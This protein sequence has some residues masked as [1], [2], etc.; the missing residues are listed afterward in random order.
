MKKILFLGYNR[1][2][3]RLIKFLNNLENYKVECFQKKLNL[4]KASK[5]DVII[6]FGY[7]YI[8]PIYL[9]KKLKKKI[10]NLHIGYLPYNRGAHPNFWSFID[11]TPKGVTIH[12]IDKNIDTGKIIYQKIV[13]FEFYKNY[14]SLT[15]K[16]TYKRLIKEIEDLFI[17]NHEDILNKK[18]KSY[19]QINIG[20]FHNKSDLPKILKSWNQNI[21]STVKKYKLE[22]EKFLNNKL[23]LISKIESTRKNNNI[24]WMNVVRHSLKLNPK[25]TLAILKSINQDDKKISKYF[26]KLNE[27]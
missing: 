19:N 17:R 13:D 5:Y 11:N 20:T 2:K 21:F 6:S 4:K 12:E 7:K 10:I 26:E 14:K 18:Y 27:N 9:I 23:D 22:N 25:K 24:N 3:T 16:I 8:L 15:F 1:N